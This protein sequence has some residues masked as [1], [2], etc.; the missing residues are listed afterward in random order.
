[1]KQ[2]FLMLLVLFASFT[3]WAKVPE[4]SNNGI[5]FKGV[6]VDKVS[7]ETLAGVKVTIDGTNLE[8]YTNFDGEFEFNGLEPG[9]YKINCNLITYNEII[10]AKIQVTTENE[11]KPLLLKIA[12]T[13][14]PE[15]L[16]DESKVKLG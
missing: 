1:M 13:R 14:T 10:S 7:G 11:I 3:T 4:A 5:H 12:P 9:T 15:I 6:V 16:S 8:V 2:N